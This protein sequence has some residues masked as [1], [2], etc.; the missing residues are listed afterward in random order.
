MYWCQFDIWTE[1]TSFF[2]V[3]KANIEFYAENYDKRMKNDLSILLLVD[4]DI[5]V[6]KI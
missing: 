3:N 5:Y 4:R 2:K 1:S 6:H